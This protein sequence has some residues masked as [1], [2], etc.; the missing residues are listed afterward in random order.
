MSEP[1][2]TFAALLTGGEPPTVEPVE[3]VEPAPRD[4][5]AAF[6]NGEPETPAA[7]PEPAEPVN[8]APAANPHQGQGGPPLP[9]DPFGRLVEHIQELGARS[10]ARRAWVTPLT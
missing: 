8:R 9:Y 1:R 5:F 4:L 3:P 7:E 6:V 2:D 10:Q